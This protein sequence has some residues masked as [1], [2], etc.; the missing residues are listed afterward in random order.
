MKL[1]YLLEKDAKK[2][3]DIK[4]SNACE[5]DPEI[6]SIHLRAQDVKPGGMFIAIKGEK[7]DG[8]DFIDTALEKGAAAIIT[9][10]PVNKNAVVIQVENT[11]KTLAEISSRFYD[12]PSEKLVIIGITGTNGKTTTAY[13]IESILSKSGIKAGVIGTVNYRYKDKILNPAMTT[14][15]SIELQKILYE[16]HKDNITHVV[17]EV[18]SHAIDLDRINCCM[19]DIG[20]FTNLTQDHLD[21]HKTMDIYWQCKKKMFTKHLAKSSKTNKTAVINCGNHKGKELFEAISGRKI[22]V[23][24]DKKHTVRLSK[25]SCDISGIKGVFCIPNHEFGF[26]SSLVGKYNAENLAC[27]AGVGVALNLDP[28]AIEAGIENV[29]YVPGRLEHVDNDFKRHIYVDYAHTPD[30]LGNVLATM[31]SISEKKLICVFGCGG[32]R[33]KT[34]RSMMGEVA[35]HFC[36]LVII[37]SDNPRTEDPLSIIDNIAKGVKKASLQ[38]IASLKIKNKNGRPLKQKK[39]YIIEPDRKKAIELS[40]S[41]SAPGD[42]IVIAGKG[43]ETYQIFGSKKYFFDDRTETKKALQTVF[44]KRVNN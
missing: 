17:M 1:S 22:S 6:S 23:G 31:K 42:T 40:L 8:H 30:A 16:M 24:T 3:A 4:E 44:K 33:D 12:N 5:K 7:A 11:R 21:Y 18:S 2:N 14:P 34:K 20:V 10:K 15:E 35:G 26:M 37:T 27:A 39:G 9:Q 13:L 41:E 36:D 38:Q 19:F 29:H 25:L 43:H 32:D 28:H